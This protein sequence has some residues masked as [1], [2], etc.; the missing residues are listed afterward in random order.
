MK[1][2]YIFFALHRQDNTRQTQNTSNYHTLEKFIRARNKLTSKL[3][4]LHSWIKNKKFITWWRRIWHFLYCS[5]YFV[6]LFSW[7]EKE[8][9]KKGQCSIVQKVSDWE[10]FITWY[11]YYYAYKKMIKTSNKKL[12]SNSNFHIEQ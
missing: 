12:L 9:R 10:S 8:K 5:Q 11:V 7:G 3:N 1:E 4:I 6:S 2:V